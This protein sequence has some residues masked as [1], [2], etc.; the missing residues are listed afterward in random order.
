MK[1]YTFYVGENE[2]I[3]IVKNKDKS[4][5]HPKTYIID[6]DGKT[7]EV[8]EK[9]Y[10][11][12]GYFAEY[13]T[14]IDG[15]SIGISIREK[16]YR[17]GASVRISVDGINYRGLWFLYTHCRKQKMALC[18]H[19]TINCCSDRYGALSIRA[20]EYYFGLFFLLSLWRMALQRT[21]RF[22]TCLSE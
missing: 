21:C 19:F 18:L 7:K 12:P 22:F 6:I 14:K 17:S 4:E 9:Y 2:H 11:L 15:H 5:T 20:C 3:L 13:V 16:A 1:P 8:K 10:E